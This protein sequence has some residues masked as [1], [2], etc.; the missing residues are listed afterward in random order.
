[1]TPGEFAAYVKTMHS[2]G[3]T[4]LRMGDI[5][6]ELGGKKKAPIAP[7]MEIP[8]PDLQ[9]GLKLPGE[10][11]VE[12]EKIKHRHEQLKSL[13]KL[14]DMDLVDRLFPEPSDPFSEAPP[15]GIL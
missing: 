1:M 8:P 14:D 4:S 15:E 3:V 12:P 7:K 6:I 5:H 9:M 2:M 10:P 13:L 11:P